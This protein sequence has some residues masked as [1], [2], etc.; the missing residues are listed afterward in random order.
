ML[1]RDSAR[2]MLRAFQ[3]TKLSEKD[4]KKDPELKEKVLGNEASKIRK[5]DK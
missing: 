5:E 3:N 2:Q 4:R 1:M